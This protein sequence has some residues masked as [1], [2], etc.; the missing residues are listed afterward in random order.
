[1]SRDHERDPHR[2]SRVETLSAW[3]G[4]WKPRDVE[5]P[6]VPKRKLG[7][8]L[9]FLVLVLAVAAAVVVPAIESGK[10][11]GE[12]RERRAAAEAREEW[13][14]RLR[15]EQAPHRG[16]GRPVRDAASRAA[17]LERVRASIAAD[18]RR[19]V[20]A[21]ELDGAIRRVDCRP[22]A[23][24]GTGNRRSF[25]CTAVTRDI[26]AG[27]RNVTGALGHPFIVVVDFATGRF[28]W[29]KTNPVPGE[30]VVPDPRNVVEL[31]AACLL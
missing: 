30:R 25:D 12:A 9:A 5:V 10:D 18:A 16:S 6:R 17:L 27:P 28:T 26:P 20:A 24:P 8:A 29:C 15:V 11:E 14:E 13:R 19:R 31:P 3:L 2:L 22:S 7:I 21:G 23:R 1:M 4:L